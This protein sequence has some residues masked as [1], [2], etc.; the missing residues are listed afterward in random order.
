MKKSLLFLSIF[1]FLF[2]FAGCS[3]CSS[4]DESVE[5]NM[6][7]VNYKNSDFGY[8]LLLPGG[9]KPK[10][11]DAEM[12]KK[13]G[14]KLFLFDGCRIDVTAKKME[15]AT[16][17]TAEQA[18]KQSF[19]IQRTIYDNGQ[20][21]M[22]DSLSY[23]VRAADSDNLNAHAAFMKY[24]IK[25]MIDFTYPSSNKEKFDKDLDAVVKSFK[26]Q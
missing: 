5:E 20:G 12:E 1:A 13:R 7:E 9:F 8:S 21:E 10:T 26:M 2:V 4:S 19:E 11:D 17:T 3:G 15:L 25:Y 18:I 6:K 14:G 16:G 23:L 24:D 22:L